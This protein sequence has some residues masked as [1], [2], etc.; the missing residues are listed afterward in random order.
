M[1]TLTCNCFFLL[2]TIRVCLEGLAARPSKQTRMVGST[3]GVYRFGLIFV[4]AK[5]NKRHHHHDVF[6]LFLQK[7]KIGAKLH[8]PSFSKV[9]TIRGCLQNLYII[10]GIFCVFVAFFVCIFCIFVCI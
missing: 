8:I 5:T 4:S 7:Q 2:P 6:Y 1:L 9:R 10:F 3:L